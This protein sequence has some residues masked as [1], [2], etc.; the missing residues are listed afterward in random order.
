[1]FSY[2]ISDR[3]RKKLEKIGRKDK[4]L[5]RNFYRKIQEVI[6]RDGKSINMYKNLKSPMNEYKRIHLTDNYVLL[7]A[8]EKDHIVFIDIR[9]RDDVYG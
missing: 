1:M 7:F 5:A 6:S 8:V 4:V 9:H 2:D 3:L